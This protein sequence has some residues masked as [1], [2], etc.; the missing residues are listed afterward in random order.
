MPNNAEMLFDIES[1]LN[2]QD[3]PAFD[4]KG[5]KLSVVERVSTMIELY[6]DMETVYYS[7]S[8]HGLLDKYAIPDTSF[9]GKKL[10]DYG[11]ILLILMNINTLLNQSGIHQ[12]LER[13]LEL[14][15]SLDCQCDSYNGFTCSLHQDRYQ[16]TQ[17]LRSFESV[18]QIL[19]SVKNK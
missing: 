11:R 1:I 7:N 6:Q 9:D 3:V 15:D 12:T 16:V 5:E 10:S 18:N 19:G 8:I 14:I 4:E 2:D 17:S 13:C